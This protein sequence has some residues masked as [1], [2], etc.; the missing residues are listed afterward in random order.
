MTTRPKKPPKTYAL[1]P[2]IDRTEKT[3]QIKA[4]YNKR[5]DLYDKNLS[6]IE[7]VYDIRFK[8]N[9]RHFQ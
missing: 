1:E 3:T 5:R 8:S 6:L 4:N 7:E 2:Y 9:D